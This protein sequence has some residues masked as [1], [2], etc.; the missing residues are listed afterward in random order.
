MTRNTSR[1]NVNVPP[2]GRR[3]QQ[4][5]GCPGGK[6]DGVEVRVVAALV[7]V[8]SRH[9]NAITNGK[10]AMASRSQASSSYLSQTWLKEQACH[11]SRA[12][13]LRITS[14]TNNTSTNSIQSLDN[15]AMASQVS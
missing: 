15:L 6:S 5:V 9:N 13:L 2:T 1:P 14:G 10:H 8:E 11:D 4:A 3:G 12:P 7:E